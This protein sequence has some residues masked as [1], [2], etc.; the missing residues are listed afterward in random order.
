MSTSSKRILKKSEGLEGG[1]ETEIKVGSVYVRACICVCV[2]VCLLNVSCWRVCR[3]VRVCVCMCV[4]M[5]V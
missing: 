3:Y 1:D 4:C 2:C 5:C